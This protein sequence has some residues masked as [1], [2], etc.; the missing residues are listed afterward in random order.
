MRITGQLADLV[1]ETLSE[2]YNKY[3]NIENVVKVIHVEMLRALYGI[4]MS[5][6]FFYKHFRKDLESI[7]LKINPYDV[8]VANRI[9]NKQQQMITWHVDDI[10]GSHT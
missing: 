6:L 4:M 7:R 9:V 8:C 3:I 1:L 2:K 5:S 10:K